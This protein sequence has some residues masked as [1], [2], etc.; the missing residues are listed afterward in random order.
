M[1]TNR[2]VISESPTE[3][4]WLSLIGPLLNESMGGPLAERSDFSGIKRILD[5]GCGPGS[6]VLEVARE[7]SEIEVIG[8]DVSRAALEEGASHARVRGYANAHFQYMDGTEPLPFA[9]DSFDLVNARTIM[10][11]MTPE[12]WPNLLQECRRILRHAGTFRITEFTEGLTNSAAAGRFW[13]FYSQ[14]L[15][16][17]G[18]SFDP[19][20]RHIGII[21]ELPRLL[22][23]AKF[24]NVQL[25]AHPIEH[26]AGTSLH[27][28]WYKNYSIVIKLLKPFVVSAGVMTEDEFE[29]FYLQFQGEFE[30]P[31]FTGLE[32]YLTV[33]GEKPA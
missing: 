1:A 13:S 6:W 26:S 17:T 21:N 15:H 16:A 28:G 27:E 8:I 5:L 25:K 14:A 19:D 32:I 23:D 10:G 7:H 4:E 22:R 30:S 20:G 3:V 2:F 18:R 29:T 11:F 33:W 9:S 31:K 24:T 12:L